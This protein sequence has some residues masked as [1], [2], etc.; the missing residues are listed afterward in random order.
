M[1]AIQPVEPNDPN[2]HT[3]QL[4]VEEQNGL[5][6]A[7]AAPLI[8]AGFRAQIFDATVA[9]NLGYTH[10]STIKQV[11]F[12]GTLATNDLMREA[13]NAGISAGVMQT[14]P[15]C[16]LSDFMSWTKWMKSP[17]GRSALYK[18]QQDKKLQ[19]KMTEG[20]SATDMAIVKCFNHMKQVF[21]N[22][23]KACT[24][25]REKRI[26]ELRTELRHEERALKSEL[27]EIA[28]KYLPV[29]EYQEPDERDINNLAY[30]LYSDDAVL[31]GR[32][33][34]IRVAGGLE[35]ALRSF[36]ATARE[37]LERN[38]AVQQ[39]Y[40][41]ALMSFMSSQLFRF[42][43]PRT[44]EGSRD[45]SISW[46]PSLEALLWKKPLQLRIR[47]ADAVPIGKLG[48]PNQELT[49]IP[50][51]RVLHGPLLAE[52]RTEG[53]RFVPAPGRGIERISL[54][55]QTL[56]NPRL[57]VL[58]KFS[59]ETPRSIPTAR[60]K[61]EA[62]FRRIIGGGVMQNWQIDSSMYRGGGNSFD[63]LLLLDQARCDPPGRLLRDKFTPHLARLALSLGDGFAVPDGKESVQMKNFNNDATSGPFL[64]RFGIKK[65]HGLKTVIEREMWQY[66]DDYAE[67]RIDARGLPH[68][69]ARIGFRTKLL[70]PESY[71]EKM[72][73]GKA[74]G[75]AVMMLDALEQS[76]SSPLYNVLSHHTFTRRLE[77]DFGFKNAAIRA[78][79]DW[80]RLWKSVSK[81]ACIIELDWS[82]FDRERPAEDLEFVVQV[83]LSCFRPESKREERLLE[84]Y[85]I[86]MRRALIFR[87]LITDNGGIMH[88]DGMVPSGSLWTGWIDTALNIL[89]LKAACREAGF[90]QSFYLPMCAGD[91][92]LTLFWIDRGDEP[93]LRIRT[94]LNGW[95]RAGIE[96]ED[97]HIFRPPYHV[98]KRQA[99]F[100]QDVDI[101]KGTSKLMHKAEWVEFDGEIQIDE[102]KGWSHRWEY[103]FKDTPKFLSCHWLIDG[104]PIRPTGDNLEKLLFPEGIHTSLDDYAA[105]VASMVVDNPFNHHNVNHMLMRYVIIQQVKAMDF[106]IVPVSDILYMCKFRSK[107][108][109]MVPFPQV[110]PW[111]RG[112]EHYRM[113]DYDGVSDWVADFQN[114][115]EGV[116][117]LYLRQ[118]EGGVDAYVFMDII[119]GDSHVGEGQF[120]NDMERWMNWLRTHPVTRYLRGVR[121]NRPRKPSVSG[122]ADLRCRVEN[123]YEQMRARLYSGRISSAASFAKFCVA[124]GGRTERP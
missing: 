114:F 26:E 59:E 60:S 81:A 11:K 70:S 57:R 110:A 84:A 115:I 91:D 2:A 111:R 94:L 28:V 73:S 107:D 29:A 79:S 109:E 78:S 27:A 122:D 34:I 40:R 93:L 95:F 65:K 53:A 119:R 89:Y 120:G 85:G 50:L 48:R 67:G 42:V 12:A 117:S 106:G 66:Y 112:D 51:S 38:H 124:L 7:A 68:F 15:Y 77:E 123:A 22:E 31:R 54:N 36:G 43:N 61:F 69:G 37:I 32:A 21:A 83:V 64:R 72:R 90:G 13:I 44:K 49:R 30:K 58:A 8:D 104:Q 52:T 17:P 92:N 18:A 10:A 118:P 5:L 41:P 102:S 76:A 71:I 82:K 14:Q 35:E 47:H 100:P 9:A 62:A 6:V 46:L 3:A 87:L 55:S 20:I 88:M 86:M 98:K 63:A 16:T 33:P 103:A 105:A 96:A 97:F 39:Q 74:F 116:S 1:A 113:E 56:H 19:K 108:G 25:K 121:G 4:T 75:R 24:Q 99:I 101:T 80:P 23:K 45:R